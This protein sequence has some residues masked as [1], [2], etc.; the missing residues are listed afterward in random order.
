MQYFVD[1]H[2]HHHSTTIAG[3]ASIVTSSTWSP[4]GRLQFGMHHLLTTYLTRKG[5]LSPYLRGLSALV[6]CGSDVNISTCST[7]NDD[8]AW[9]CQI[10]N[11]FAEII[12]GT[13]QK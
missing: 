10:V 2:E 7:K 8:G 3:Q 9:F 11:R 1:H 4:T 12:Y 5:L 6:A 13:V